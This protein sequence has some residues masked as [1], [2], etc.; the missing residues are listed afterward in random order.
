M[1]ELVTIIMKLRSNA[2][3]I[4]L[5]LDKACLNHLHTTSSMGVNYISEH[6]CY[7]QFLADI[8]LLFPPDKSL[9]LAIGIIVDFFTKEGVAL[10]RVIDWSPLILAH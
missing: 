3:S 10:K 5:V 2:Q 9:K 1:S 7:G 8:L 6:I 4:S